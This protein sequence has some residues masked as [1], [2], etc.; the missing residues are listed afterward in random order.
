MVNR[1]R[2]VVGC[3]LISGKTGRR[4]DIK[5]FPRI[6]RSLEIGLG[7]MQSVF[8]GE[9]GVP[10]EIAIPRK[11]FTSI[12]ASSSSVHVCISRS[13]IH[14]GIILSF[15]F[16]RQ[17]GRWWCCSWQMP[18][19]FNLTSSRVVWVEEGSHL[20]AAGEMWALLTISADWPGTFQGFWPWLKIN[21]N[22]K[23]F[24]QMIERV[25]GEGVKWTENDVSV[26]L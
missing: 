12:T 26:D 3:G 17:L 11:C 16:F 23:D 18:W 15:T 24:R 9:K 10:V 13:H 20:L 1:K 4:L 21:G 7:G 5:H 14:C 8:S 25:L 19:I 6:C 22:F 2:T